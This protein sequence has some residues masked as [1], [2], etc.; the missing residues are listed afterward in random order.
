[1]RIKLARTLLVLGI[2]LPA[3][4]RADEIAR[5]LA[6]PMAHPAVG[7]IGQTGAARPLIGRAAQPAV[8]NIGQVGRSTGRPPAA[9]VARADHR[10]IV[11]APR[12]KPTAPPRRIARAV[13]TVAPAHATVG[14]VLPPPTVLRQPLAL[15]TATLPRL[16]PLVT[17]RERPA[18]GNV[19]RGKGKPRV[20]E[21][22]EAAVPLVDAEQR[23]A[24]GNVARGKAMDDGE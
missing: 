8:G 24:V 11:I 20:R 22:L 12:V 1:M 7:N 5:P 21:D 10:E 19:V 15:Q 16:E 2:G 14:E 18:T 17:R 4:E 13:A 3:C 9:T 6:D 23:P